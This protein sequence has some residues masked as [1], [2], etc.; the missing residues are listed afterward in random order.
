MLADDIIAAVGS[1]S[2]QVYCGAFAPM[3]LAIKRAQRF[4]L[5]PEVLR[6]ALTI[7]KSAIGPQLRALPLC[8]LPFARCWFEWPG[9]VGGIPKRMGALVSTD[10]S[11]QRGTIAYAWMHPDPDLGG[12]NIC[13]LLVTFDWRETPEPVADIMGAARWHTTATD[14]DWRKLATQFDRV[15]LSARADVEEETR[16]F[17]I[18]INPMMSKFLTFAEATSREALHKILA[19]ASLDVEGEPP[20][21]RAAIMLLNSRNLAVQTARPVAAKLNRARAARGREPL[22][23]YTHIGIRLTRAL[24]ARAGMAGDPRHAARLHL[25]RGH[26]KI[27]KSGVY[28][29]SPFARGTTDGSAPLNQHRHV[30]L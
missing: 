19:A 12:V 15:R 7:S 11:L 14:Q 13:P 28:W 29:W 1:A 4:D 16:R 2:D 3:A 26:F 30:G 23:D 5:S 6:S 10:A 18:A 25:V 21:L 17:G 24:A 9:N 20:M 8:R 27:R 22:L